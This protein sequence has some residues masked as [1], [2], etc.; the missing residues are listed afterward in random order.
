MG[1]SF[2]PSMSWMS[3][4][5]AKN[6]CRRGSTGARATAPGMSTR[7][8]PWAGCCRCYQVRFRVVDG[9]QDVAAALIVAFAL[10]RQ[11]QAA[12]GAVQEPHLQVALQALDDAGDGGRRHRQRF[13][14]LVEAVRFHDAQKHLHSLNSIHGCRKTRWTGAAPRN[15][16]RSAKNAGAAGS[17]LILPDACGGAVSMPPTLGAAMRRITADCVPPPASPAPGRPC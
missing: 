1:R 10:G 17:F 11:A 5:R 8:R 6:S 14:R 3:G 9:L 15:Y 13:G 16:S 12:R 4:Y 2:M 7:S